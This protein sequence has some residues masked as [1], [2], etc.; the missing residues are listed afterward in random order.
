MANKKQLDKLLSIKTGVPEIDVSKVTDA[1]PSQLGQWLKLHGA[2]QTGDYEGD[3]SGLNVWLEL[4]ESETSRW[5]L[6]FTP[7]ASFLSE[8]G[9]NADRF[10]SNV[11]NN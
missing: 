8:F 1:L 3:F 11:V 5:A 2:Q 6:T 7:D 10:G 9:N 4:D